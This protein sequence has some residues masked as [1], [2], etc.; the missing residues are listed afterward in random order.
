MLNLA[1][2]EVIYKD[3]RAKKAIFCEGAAVVKNNYF[4]WLPFGLV[5]GE[6]IT[7]KMDLLPELI[8]SKD[9]FLLPVKGAAKA[10]STYDRN[11]IDANI[12]GGARDYLVKKLKELLKNKF[13]VVG[14]QA[15]I[16]P[17]TKDRRPF[18]GLHPQ[19]KLIGLFNGLGTKGVSL[20]PYCS[21][22]FADFLVFNKE[23]DQEADLHRYS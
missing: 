10:G 12:T 15:G 18:M 23:F 14:Q 11:N 16:R 6:I 4:N 22:Q 8:I 17:G 19:T 9:I 7:L 1:D 3:L 2:Q 5:K 13:E 20:G 21:D